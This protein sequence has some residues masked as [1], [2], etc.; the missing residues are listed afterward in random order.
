MGRNFQT[1]LDECL[2]ELETGQSLDAILARYPEEADELRPLLLTA[3]NLKSMPIA[4]PRSHVQQA[5]WQRF[6]GQAIALRRAR[7][8]RPA[9]S[10]WRPL[11]AAASFVLML[12]LA[13]GA[14]TYAA[15]R[16]LPD[17]PLYPLKLA[18]EEARLWFVFDEGDRA[19]T[20]LDQT[21]TR[22]TEISKLMEQGKPVKGN[23]LSAMRGRMTRATNIIDKSDASPELVSRADELSA[24]QEQMLIVIGQNVP[25]DDSDEYGK[26]LVVVHETRLDLQGLSSEQALNLEPLDLAQG[27][28]SFTGLVEQQQDGSWIISGT[29]ILVDEATIV[30]GNTGEVVGQVAQ[31]TTIRGPDAPRALDISLRGSEDLAKMATI[32]GVIDSVQGDTIQ[33]GG[34]TVLLSQHILLDGQLRQGTTVEVV[35]EA[36]EGQTFEATLIHVTP[37][38]DGQDAFVYEGTLEQATASQWQVSGRTFE[39]DASTNIDAGTLLIQPGVNARVEG[40]CRGSD[41]VAKRIV[42]LAPE[43]PP[44]TVT[45][46]GVFQ[47]QADGA[48]LIGGIPIDFAPESPALLTPPTGTLV[49]VSGSQKGQAIVVTTAE[50]TRPPEDLGLVKLEGVASQLDN[51]QWQIGPAPFRTSAVT[52]V[53]GQLIPGARAIV[54]ALP[55]E[56]GSLDAIYIDVLDTHSLLAPPTV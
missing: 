29:K 2:K 34:R 6:L 21:E 49:K 33:V 28:G 27:V 22:M 54:W 30:E 40:V 41:L 12:F 39:L 43:G 44:E 42:L 13:G 53:T 25:A 10:L 14:T 18:T 51:N 38:E 52:R 11:A 19:G 48:W 31:V 1:I 23:V 3:Q 47:G 17:S 45:V 4:R 35:G 50:S 8:R 36:G 16:S 37:T 56:D 9:L 15:S 32:S 5:G 46:E 24:R 20:L 7:Q 55:S 26:V